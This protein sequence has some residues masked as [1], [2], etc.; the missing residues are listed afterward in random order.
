VEQAV[1]LIYTRDRLPPP[2][3]VMVRLLAAGLA[4]GCLAM[5]VIGA[6]LVPNGE[7]GVSTHTQVGLP[8][9]EFERKMGIPCPSCGFTTSVSY[10]AHGNVLASIYVQPMGFL[11]AVFAAATVWVGGYI[12]VTGRPVHRL[13]LQVPGKIWLIGLLS[14]A[15]VAWAWKIAIHLTGHD[16]WPP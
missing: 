7:K 4:V 8:P 13:M 12:A 10:F 9:C 14:L 11:I 3:S 2:M 6:K 1:P 5:L 16:H 15:V